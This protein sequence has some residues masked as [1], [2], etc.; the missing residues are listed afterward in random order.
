[1]GKYKSVNPNKV[2]RKYLVLKYGEQCSRCGWNQR[3]DLTNRVPIEVEHIDGNWQNN[4]LSNLTLLCPNCHSL[5]HSFR[6]LNRGKG[7]PKRLGGRE[8]PIRTGSLQQGKKSSAM[9]LPERKR[10]EPDGRL[11]QL[12]LVL[13]A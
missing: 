2:I 10:V 3:H 7:R 9:R 1:M 13:P 8:N 4:D 6:G 5:T 12:Q 11:T